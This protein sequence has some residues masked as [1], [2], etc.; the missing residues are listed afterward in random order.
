LYRAEFQITYTSG[1]V[2]TVPDGE[3]LIE[4][5]PDLGP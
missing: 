5:V 3:L 2:E 4:I 1:E